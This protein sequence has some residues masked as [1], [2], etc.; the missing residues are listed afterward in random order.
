MRGALPVSSNSL[1]VKAISLL[2][3][4][5]LSAVGDTA[6]TNGDQPA[7]DET[8]WLALLDRAV[9]KLASAAFTTWWPK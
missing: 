6:V 7:V 4:C 9:W 3:L 5:T 8:A 2:T 1:C